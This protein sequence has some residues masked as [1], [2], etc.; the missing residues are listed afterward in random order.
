MSPAAYALPTA[1]RSGCSPVTRRATSAS[2]VALRRSTPSA[3]RS[4]AAP[5]VLGLAPGTTSSRESTSAISR[6][7]AA[8]NRDC[9]RV[10]ARSA[11]LSSA[12][13]RAVQRLSARSAM[14][15]CSRAIASAR[16]GSPAKISS[17]LAT[18]AIRAA[19]AR[20]EVIGATPQK[21]AEFARALFVRPARVTGSPVHVHDATTDHRQTPAQVIS[22]R[23]T[24]GTQWQHHSARPDLTQREEPGKRH[25]EGGRAI[26]DRRG[27]QE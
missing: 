20:R 21:P 15:A 2:R 9:S 3:V 26:R 11:A 17:S 6:R 24:R 8:P 18:R 1:S 16:Y 23:E 4:S 12:G 14:A 19:D 25:G 10:T 27:Q 5:A 7:A 13:P 22:Q